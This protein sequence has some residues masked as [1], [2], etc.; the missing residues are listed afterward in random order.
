MGSL[1]KT[2]EKHLTKFNIIND[3]KQKSHHMR[4][5]DFLSLLRA[6]LQKVS[7]QALAGTVRSALPKVRSR[8][9][10]LPLPLRSQSLR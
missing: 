4:K 5:R 9:S 10:A 6:S 7:R 8:E 3:L 2:E 1:A